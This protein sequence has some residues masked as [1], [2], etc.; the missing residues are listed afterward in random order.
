[1]IQFAWFKVIERYFICLHSTIINWII[2][3]W[4]INCQ[5]STWTRNESKSL[6]WHWTQV[7]GNWEFHRKIKWRRT[8]FTMWS[9]RL[10]FCLH[11]YSS[12]WFSGWDGSSS[13]TISLHTVAREFHICKFDKFLLKISWNNR[14]AKWFQNMLQATEWKLMK[15]ERESHLSK[16]TFTIAN[17]NDAKYI[18]IYLP[19][20]D[21]FV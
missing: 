18:P 12:N 7:T 2:E 10:Q 13:S 6:N 4:L 3:I 5:R 9:W 15:D 8:C 17:Q 14:I 16:K 21:S 19:R 20:E 11:F 1:M